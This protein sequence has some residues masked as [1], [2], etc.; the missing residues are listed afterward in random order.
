MGKMPR[1]DS[2]HP[3]A[4]ASLTLTW[5]CKILPNMSMEHPKNLK[6]TAIMCDPI[7]LFPQTAGSDKGHESALE[8]NKGREKASTTTVAVWP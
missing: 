7:N 1:S 3:P 5:L 2:P 6:M 4:I 8:K